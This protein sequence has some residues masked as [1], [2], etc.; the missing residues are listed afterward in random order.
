M[1]EFCTSYRNEV[2]E[3]EITKRKEEILMKILKVVRLT[4]FSLIFSA[5]LMPQAQ[6][7]CSLPATTH[8]ANITTLSDLLP[9]DAR[10]A[11]AVDISALLA[12]S[13]AA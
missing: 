12:G 11:L 13:S 4:L 2:Q 9:D 6:A 1:P 10:G 5:V 7:V 8:A 3:A